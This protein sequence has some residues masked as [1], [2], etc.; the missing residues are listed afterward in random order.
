MNERI[1][2]MG[3]FNTQF[4]NPHGLSNALNV[5][6]ALDLI[7]VSMDATK[8]ILFNTIMNTI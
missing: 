5:S 6:T 8:N 2:Y 7:K 1:R 4:S 3:L